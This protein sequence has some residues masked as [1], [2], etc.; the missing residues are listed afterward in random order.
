MSTTGKWTNKVVFFP[1]GWQLQQLQ[2]SSARSEG[3]SLETDQHPF[4][5]LTSISIYERKL[6]LVF[7]FDWG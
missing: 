7:N 4:S 2:P 6:T 1:F 5:L 3:S